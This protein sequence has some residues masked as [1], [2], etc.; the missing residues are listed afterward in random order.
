[1][2]EFEPKIISFLCNWCSYAGADLA[3]I[4]RIQYPTNI[5]V[6]R[7]MCSGRVDPIFI[8]EGFLSGFDGVLVLGCHPG[9]CHY[10]TGNYQAEK[11]IKM[12][13]RI[14]DIA[15][16]NSDRVYLD[17]VSAGEGERFAKIV[18]DFT[19]KIKQIGSLFNGDKSV[20]QQLLIV[21]KVLEEEKIRWLIGKQK[22]LTEVGNVFNEKIIEDEFIQLLER[23]LRDEYNKN[24]IIQLLKDVPLKVIEIAKYVK[25]VPDVVSSYLV[26]LECEGK[27][28]LHSIEER[29]PKYIRID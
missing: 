21:K 17:W 26:D 27:I 10:L 6:I 23:N 25:L 2:K 8:I 29:N 19:N 13:K 16:I 22:E 14:L 28:T 4:S 15:E 20:Q 1:M 24:K 5:R 7:V 3:G 12:T 9:D 18:T 11:K